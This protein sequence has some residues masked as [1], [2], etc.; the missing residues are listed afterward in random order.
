MDN[1]TWRITKAQMNNIDEIYEKGN[2]ADWPYVD[3]QK[4]K[5]DDRGE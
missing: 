1:S 2:N 5:S 4:G 3:T